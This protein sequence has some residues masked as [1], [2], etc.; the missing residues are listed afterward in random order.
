MVSTRLPGAP[1]AIAAVA[2][3]EAARLGALLREVHES[4]RGPVGGLWSWDAPAGSLA[5]YRRGRARDTEALLAGGPDAGLALAAA[6]SCADDDD[7]GAAPFRLLHGDLVEANIVWG[8]RV[9]SRRLGVLADGRSGRGP[10]VPDRAERPLRG[11]GR[12]RDGRLWAGGDGRPDRGMATARGGRRG[13][14]VSRGGHGAGGLA[15]LRRARALA[16]AA[17]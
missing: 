14:L 16:D 7:D 4:R 3:A 6:A 9:R 5:D 13:G 10:G 11:G 1:R 17:R 2:P 15:L 8:R 12:G